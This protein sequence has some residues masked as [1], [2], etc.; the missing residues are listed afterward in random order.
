MSSRRDI[1]AAEFDKALQP[2]IIP[3]KPCG[4]YLELVGE[5]IRQEARHGQIKPGGMVST[6][7][8]LPADIRTP[9]VKAMLAADNERELGRHG[10][11]DRVCRDH[12]VDK[13]IVN[14]VMDHM[15]SDYVAWSLQERRGSDADLPLPE[16]T[17]RDVISAAMG[18]GE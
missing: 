10:D 11:L 5:T 2:P 14:A 4:S 16:I 7:V 12:E 17:R 6:I 15:E 9:V 18:D 8:G 3:V 1:L 13:E